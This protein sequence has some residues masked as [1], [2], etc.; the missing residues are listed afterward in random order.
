MSAMRR[1][2][3]KWKARNMM[4]D[5]WQIKIEDEERQLAMARIAKDAAELVNCAIEAKEEISEIEQMLSDNDHVRMWETLQ[6]FL[7]KYFLFIVGT[8]PFTNMTVVPLTKEEI[9]ILATEALRHQLKLLIGFIYAF[10][11][12]NGPRKLAFQTHVSQ[13]TRKLVG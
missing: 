5:N 9:R 8:S 3:L 1:D 11:A 13:L 7:A 4:E 2:E 6:K 12:L 10:H